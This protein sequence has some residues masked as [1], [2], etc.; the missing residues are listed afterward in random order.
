MGHIYK[1]DPI[2]TDHGPFCCEDDEGLL[3]QVQPLV[4]RLHVDPGGGPS[5]WFIYL[6]IFHLRMG[7]T[8]HA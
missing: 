5:R 2:V 7:V 1:P 3:V 4:A 8:F 6:F